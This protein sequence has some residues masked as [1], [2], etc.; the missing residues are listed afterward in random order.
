MR[1]RQ[2]FMDSLVAHGV[3]AIFGNPGTTENPL[4][5]SL[6][7][8]PQIPYYVA[9]HEGVAVGAASFYAQ[10]TGKTAVVNL[11]VA[12]GLG[13]GIGMIYGALKARS[14]LIVTAGQ[15]DTRLRLNEPLLSHDLVA[16]A[17][18][19]TKWSAEPRS[20]DE[21]GPMLHRAFK[22]AND[23]PSGPVFVALPVNVMEQETDVKAIASNALRRDA[24]PSAEGIAEVVELLLSS[25]AP[26]IVVGDDVAR[27]NAVERMVALAE[28]IGA[29]VWHEALRAQISFPNRHPNNRGRIPFETASIRQT[30]APHDVVVLIGGTF[31]EELWYD[32]GPIVRE[33]TKVIQIDASHERLAFSQHLHIGLVADL[34]T[35]IDQLTAALEEDAPTSFHAAA[36]ARNEVFAEAQQKARDA[37]EA[38]LQSLWDDQPMSPAR[39][40]FEIRQA[41][42]DDV[43]IVDES[44]TAS[45]EVADRFDFA[46][47]GDYYGGRGGGIG[48]AIAGVIGIKVAY[49]DRPVVALSGD[50]STMY[51]IQA[52]WSAAHHDLPI[53]FIIFSNREYRV[54]KHNLDIYRQRFDAQSNR[55]YPHMDL[56]EPVLGFVDMARGMGV[57]AAAVTDPEELGPAVATALASG[58]PYLID[59]VISGK[60][61]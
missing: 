2:V 10:A 32:E 34:P 25:S 24:A 14:P 56:N 16:M 39:A 6:I 27:S 8:Y 26:A 57:D 28:L 9:L 18:P 31:F 59:V 55:P 4:L 38:R 53:V 46:A 19:V 43:V 42:P 3:D 51:S 54:L 60:P 22:I 45:L 44:I 47:P 15:Q 49:P 13:N 29:P 48:Q 1:G 33:A 17:A 23:P 12:P 30:L 50:G 58:G 61:E 21:I 37:S 7:D 41:L 5:D 11:H 52:L 40:M 35:A 36:A 20:A